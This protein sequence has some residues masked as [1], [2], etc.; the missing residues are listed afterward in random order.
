MAI[1]KWFR[2][3]AGLRINLHLAIDQIDDPVAR[4]STAAINSSHERAVFL[5]ARI[6]DLDD[7]GNVDWLRMAF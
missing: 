4:D 2:S 7:Q 3:P 1:A 5:E 6:G